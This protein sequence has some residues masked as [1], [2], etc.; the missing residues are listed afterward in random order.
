MKNSEKYAL[1]D[2][3]L[4]S[5]PYFF[6]SINRK[7]ELLYVSPSVE[8]ILGYL[9]EKITG[10]RYTKFLDATSPLNADAEDCRKIRFEAGENYAQLRVLETSD[11]KLKVL[12]VQTYQAQDAKGRTSF[13]HG[14]A[15]DVT[16][17]YFVEQEMHSR[18]ITLEEADSR[19]SER[20]RMV[21]E[22][23]VAGMLNKSIARKLNIRERSVEKIRSRL[24]EKFNAETM[25]EV[26]SKATEFKI[27]RDVILLA[28]DAHNGPNKPA[29]RLLRRQVL[30]MKKSA[31]P[32]GGNPH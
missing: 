19:L 18:L 23:V 25:L 17:V 32:K 21:M 8:Q 3:E 27:L 30:R 16:D 15:Q 6:F 2:I 4:F 22:L 13:V 7:S 10:Q 24:V 9:P 5:E 26:I 11:S 31:K 29:S 12:K 28:H 20:E 14:I 1:P